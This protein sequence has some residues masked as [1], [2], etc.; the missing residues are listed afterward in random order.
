MRERGRRRE[1]SAT[2]LKS[3]HFIMALNC[4]CPPSKTIKAQIERKKKE[5][6]ERDGRWRSKVHDP[7]RFVCPI[8]TLLVFFFSLPAGLSVFHNKLMDEFNIGTRPSLYTVVVP[9]T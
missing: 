4:P 2:G 6:K 7:S 9:P 5:E 3:D 8:P 1:R